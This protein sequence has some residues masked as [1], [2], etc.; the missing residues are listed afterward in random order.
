MGLFFFFFFGNVNGIQPH[1]PK[2]LT[3]TTG[4]QGRTSEGTYQAKVTF[5]SGASVISGSGTLTAT[6]TAEEMNTASPASG[7]SLSQAP[8]QANNVSD[9]GYAGQTRRSRTCCV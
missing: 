1:G 3:E 4:S 9:T 5:P 2:T 6:L 7:T 8:P